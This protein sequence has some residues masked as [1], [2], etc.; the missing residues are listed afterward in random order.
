MREL[1]DTEKDICNKQIE[2]MINEKKSL[3]EVIDYA[4]KKLKKRR[5]INAKI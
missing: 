2:R 1:T 5:I 3:K 4:E